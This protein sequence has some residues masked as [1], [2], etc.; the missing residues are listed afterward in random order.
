MSSEASAARSR[1]EGEV[2]D[3]GDS[4]WLLGGDCIRLRGSKEVRGCG[5]GERASRN[6]GH[7]ITPESRGSLST[8]ICTGPRGS[9]SGEE[10]EAIDKKEDVKVDNLGESGD[11]LEE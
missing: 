1:C 8:S 9:A 3:G 4:T 5:D 6:G 10:V 11:E 7:G 2:R